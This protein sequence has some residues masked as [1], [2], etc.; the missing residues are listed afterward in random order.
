L[1]D[2]T[3]YK[4]HPEKYG[5]WLNELD[6]LDIDT[7]DNSNELNHMKNKSNLNLLSRAL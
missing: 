7:K 5:W 1:F 6:S 2:N 4:E 3:F